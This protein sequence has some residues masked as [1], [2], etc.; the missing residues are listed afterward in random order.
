MNT[1]HA[2][3]RLPDQGD[4]IHLVES[5]EATPLATPAEADG[6]TGFL[7]APFEHDDHTPIIYIG[8]T[9]HALTLADLPVE[10][11][12]YSPIAAAADGRAD[13]ARLFQLFHSA[14][15]RGT[16]SKIVLARQVSVSHTAPLP[17]LRLFR[18]ACQ[19]FPHCFIALCH[20]P[21]TGTWLTATPE[22]LLEQTDGHAHTI[23]LAGTMPAPDN[24]DTGQ[25]WSEKNRT[26]QR[27]VTDCIRQ[28]L[29]PLA[30]HM[31]ETAARTFV[32]GNV[33]HL[34]SDFRF[35]L[36]PDVSF[37]QTVAALH[38]TPA[39][40]GVPTSVARGLILRHEPPR[41][42]YSGYCGPVGASASHLFVTLRCM[43]IEGSTCRLYAGGGLVAESREQDEWLETE[44]KL[45]AMR[46]ILATACNQS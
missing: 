44:T 23:A 27:Y 43:H 35:T 10:P 16:C 1:C 18:Q 15:L 20:T 34:R 21:Q 8:G 29:A 22:I 11:T 26:E 42:Y 30:D 32:A 24:E 36:R 19:S 45:Y 31:E 7:I 12:H 14:T 38:P 25:P 13:Y 41:S 46:H 6:L 9:P 37:G 5:A 3:Y 40:C 28:R 2:I 33:M 39:V 17:P 4:R